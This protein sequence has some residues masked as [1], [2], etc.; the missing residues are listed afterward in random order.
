VKPEGLK[1]I[2]DFQQK[3]YRLSRAYNG[4]L[5]QANTARTRLQAIRRALLDS[6]AE[7]KLLDEAAAIDRKV[8]AVLRRFRGD[9]T[10]RGLESGSPST[11]GSRLNSAVFGTR[12]RTGAPTG[13]QKQNLE[14][15]SAEFSEEQPKLNAALE[16]LKRLER[17]LDAAGV[18][19]TPGRTPEW[20]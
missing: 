3:A 14:I 8:L 12:N 11:I 16:D 4:A 1:E 5:E 15:A 19:W 6:G 9:E 18:P 7:A 20:K 13:T 17:A 2:S 10:Q